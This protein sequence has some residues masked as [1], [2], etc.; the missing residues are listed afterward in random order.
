VVALLTEET[1]QLRASARGR[2]KKGVSAPS[3]ITLFSTYDLL[4]VEPHRGSDLYELRERDVLQSRPCLS[5]GKPVEAWASA[6][7]LAEL[8]MRTTEPH[9]KQTYAFKMLD[10]ALDYLEAGDATGPLLAAFMVKYLEHAGFA[11]NLDPDEGKGP[12]G[13]GSREV[14]DIAAGGI[15]PKK[16]GNEPQLDGMSPARRFVLSPAER[17][18]LQHLRVAVFDRLGDIAFTPATSLKLVDLLAAMVEHH[19]ETRLKSLEF[20]RELWRKKADARVIL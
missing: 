15:S 2:G 11:L 12:V 5:Q 8:V 13:A 9:E 1:G 7:V 3:S 6:S 18:A 4:L 10:K 14:F 19:L 16:T 17:K 20:W